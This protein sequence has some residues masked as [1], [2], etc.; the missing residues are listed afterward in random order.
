MNSFNVPTFLSHGLPPATD[1][2]DR[3]GG[4]VVIRSDADPADVVVVDVIN[5]VWYRAFQLGI[6]EVI[7]IDLFGPAF[8]SPFTARVLEIADQFLLFRIIAT[9]P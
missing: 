2:V 6:N 1:G 9:W 8:G 3:E 5:A 7:H 4:G